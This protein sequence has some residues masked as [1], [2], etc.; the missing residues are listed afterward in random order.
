VGTATA[1][2][3]GIITQTQIS[4]RPLTRTGDIL[5]TIP[6]VVISQHSGEGKA[7]QYYLRGFN[8]DHGTDLA[9]FVMGQP[10]NLPS[11]AHGQGY[12][13]IN[14][15]IPELVS[16]IAFSKGPYDAGVGDFSTAGSYHMEYRDTVPTTLSVGG[17]SFG[18]GRVLFMGSSMAGN[19][20]LLYAAEYYHD[21]GSFVKPD[22]YERY[23]GVVRYSRD[24]ESST[25]NVTGLAYNGSFGSSDQIPQRLVT[26]GILSPYGAFDPS[27]GGTTHRY[28]LSSEYKRRYGN[29]DLNISAYAFHYDLDLFSNLSYDTDDATDYYNLTANPLTCD[30]RYTTCMPGPTHTNTYTSYCPGNANALTL[31]CG[32]QREQHDNRFVTGFD[33]SRTYKTPGATSTFG[34]SMRNDNIAAAGLYLTHDRVRYPN[35]TLAEDHVVERSTSAYASSELRIGTR[36]RATPGIRLDA[37]TFDVNA[38]LAENSGRSSAALLNPKLALAYRASQRSD[39]YADFGESFHSNDARGV[40][41]TIDPQ[42]HASFDATGAPVGGVSPLVRGIGEEIGYRYADRKLNVTAALWRLD[43]ASEL[44]FDGD[45]A[46]TNPGR[47]SRRQGIEISTNYAL[48][49]WLTLDGDYA[50]SSAVFTTDPDHIGTHIPEAIGTVISLGGTMQKPG[51]ETTLRMRCFGPRWL[52]EDGSARS[53]ASTLWNAQLTAKPS[54]RTRITLDVLN[55][56][57]SNADDVEYYYGSWTPTDARNPAYA[58]NPAVNPALGGAGVNDYLIH[59]TQKRSVRLTVSRR[60]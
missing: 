55:I 23:N 6:G 7:N 53:Q 59:R 39:V 26:T 46:Q 13:D 42:T 33:A 10:I 15:V 20:R 40:T 45:T 5:E 18:Y 38:N 27:D 57:N 29:S 12:S 22:N 35:G 11:H 21:D 30:A 43:L 60:V 2:S 3:Q 47:P 17:G 14:W 19:G 8:L 36:L 51:Y 52:I 44:V 1:A 31:S 48:T 37:Y 16:E 32:D 58:S 9:G 50:A 24:T 49:P 54:S 28:A 56:L 34:V 4:T 41:Q 25:F